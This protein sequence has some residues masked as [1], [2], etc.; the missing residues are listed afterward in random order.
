MDTPFSWPKLSLYLSNIMHLKNVGVICS[1]LHVTRARW[2]ELYKVIILYC[3]SQDS[4]NSS[5]MSPL[6]LPLMQNALN[7]RYHPP[8]LSLSIHHPPPHFSQHLR[9]LRLS[10]LPLHLLPPPMLSNQAPRL[11]TK[12]NMR[13]GLPILQSLLI[14]YTLYLSRAPAIRTQCSQMLRP[15][16]QEDGG[17]EGTQLGGYGVCDGG[18]GRG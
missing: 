8:F 10:S 2:E 18:E 3:F 13:S 14:D 12:P 6:E 4:N 16:E 15:T 1:Q 11:A 9:P 17:V 7:A 5:K